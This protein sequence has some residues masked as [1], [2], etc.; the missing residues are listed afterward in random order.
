[1]YIRGTIQLAQNR[2]KGALLEMKGAA[3]EKPGVAGQVDKLKARCRFRTS[4]GLSSG[5]P[6]WVCSNPSQDRKACNQPR[7]HAGFVVEFGSAAESAG[8]EHLQLLPCCH[9]TPPRLIAFVAAP[10]TDHS[11]ALLK[12]GYKADCHTD[13]KTK[14]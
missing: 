13:H 5:S 1:M 2:C 14:A 9:I 4:S 10:C 11:T 7:V 6:S 3:P 12:E 8:H